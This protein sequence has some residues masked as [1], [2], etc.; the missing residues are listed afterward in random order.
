MRA[1]LPAHTG[2]PILLRHGYKHQG[3]PGCSR[4]A[5]GLAHR[6]VTAVPDVS[7]AGV[8][9]DTVMRSAVGPTGN[10]GAVGARCTSVTTPRTTTAAAAVTPSISAARRNR[11]SLGRPVPTAWRG[12]ARRAAPILAVTA[13]GT[14][15]AD[16]ASVPRWARAR[17]TRS[18]PLSIAQ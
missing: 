13:A 10:G 1:F 4:F 3:K 6:R 14:S 5:D 11:V 18:S 9:T 12:A 8:D 7:P 2:S 17:R 16:S 15:G